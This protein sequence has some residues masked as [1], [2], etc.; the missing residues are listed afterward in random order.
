MHIH[1]K[2]TIIVILNYCIQVYKWF[3][4]QAVLDH[5]IS[6]HLNQ[7]PIKRTLSSSGVRVLGSSSLRFHICKAMAKQQ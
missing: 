1:V 3:G 5:E 2:I 4:L 7:M 6:E